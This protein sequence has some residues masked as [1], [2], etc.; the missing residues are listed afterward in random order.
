MSSKEIK[1][2]PMAM[3]S[4]LLNSKWDFI[5]VDALM[6]G[7]KGFQDIKNYVSK[8][9]KGGITSA[10]LSRI[11]KKL[12]ERGLVKRN[13]ITKDLE[14]IEIRY[15]LTQM[16]LDLKPVLNALREWGMKYENHLQAT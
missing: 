11:L 2:C 8:S 6:A 7:E 13:V 3:A 10:S 12:Q 5:I 15:E 16:G 1:Y 4:L 14:P 9:T